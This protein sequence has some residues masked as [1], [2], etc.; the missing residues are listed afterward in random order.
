MKINYDEIAVS[1]VCNSV[2]HYEGEYCKHCRKVGENVECPE[3][4]VVYLQDTDGNE[5]VLCLQCAPAH[6]KFWYENKMTK[7][8][9]VTK[10]LAEKEGK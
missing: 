3:G 2:L 10:Y 7:N 9:W 4:D 8:G 6:W 5:I 1:Q